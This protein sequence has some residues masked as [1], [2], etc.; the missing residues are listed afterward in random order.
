MSEEN[1]MTNKEWKIHLKK[2]IDKISDGLIKDGVLEDIG[3]VGGGMYYL[4]NG[5]YTGKDGWC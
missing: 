1:S 2:C 3:H 4:G 5:C